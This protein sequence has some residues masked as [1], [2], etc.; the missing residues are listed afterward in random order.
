MT[1]PRPGGFTLME[2]LVGLAVLAVLGA[3]LVPGLQ[4]ARE[5][6]RRNRCQHN[7]QQ[8]GI[9]LR[10]H[11]DTYRSFPPGQINK[12]HQR[13][14]VGRYAEPDEARVQPPAKSGAKGSGRHGGSWLLV[15]LPGIGQQALF[16]RW[17]FQTNVRAN[18]EAAQTEIAT[19]YCPSRRGSMQAAAAYAGCE[20]VDASWTRGG[21]DYAAC[22]GSGKAF[23][24]A[25]RQTYD[26]TGAQLAATATGG[27]SAFAQDR[28]NAGVFGVNSRTSLR[29]ISDGA[30]NVIAAA[31]R[32]VFRT[33]A[34]PDRLSSDGWAWGGPAT[35]FSTRNPPHQGLHYDEA[36]SAH[37]ELLYVLLADGSVR[38]IS[39][40]ID[41]RTWRNLSN[42]AQGS[43]VDF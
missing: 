32:R 34:P 19:Y 20:R 15:I 21:N 10:H 28:L 6:A 14:A 18:A 7:L 8:I 29:D 42:R 27:V 40:N 31:E 12:T 24:D 38:P 5:V 33:A 2:L 17:D 43:P 16:D 22:V 30:A 36:D 35:L 41:L 1:A 39:F 3:A 9:A 25:A 4:R 13:D 26:L 23:N 37:G 11:H